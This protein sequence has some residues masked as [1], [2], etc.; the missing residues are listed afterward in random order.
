T[1]KPIPTIEWFRNGNKIQIDGSRISTKIEGNHHILII[2]NAKVDETGQYIV[3]A[4]NKGG[5]DESSAFVKVH[6]DVEPPKFT[7]KLRSIEIKEGQFSELNVSVSGK[8]KPEI[9]W[10]KDG[11]ELIPDGNHIILK[12]NPDY[13]YHSI[14]IKNA[15]IDDSGTYSAKAINKVG[16]DETSAK[17]K[18]L[19]DLERPTIISGLISKK[20]KEGQTTE[21]NVT[22]T[23]KPKPEVKW[24]KDGQE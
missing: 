14:T 23:G 10:F 9:K 8:P 12:S 5:K 24:F 2:Q 1:G 18:V 3:K 22:V 19:E 20:I 21:M 16:E 4:V 7:D 13:G 15:T 6:E 17:F 11:K